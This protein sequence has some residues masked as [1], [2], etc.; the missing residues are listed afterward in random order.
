MTRRLLSIPVVVAIAVAAFTGTTA[1][2]P[3]GG[4][5]PCAD[6]TT[7]THNFPTPGSTYTLNM[8][9][10][11]AAPACIGRITYSVFVVNEASTPENP[12]P[13]HPA[14]L[15]GFSIDGN[16]TFTYTS[17]DD[18]I[19]VY[20]T[21][22]AKTGRVIDRAPDADATPNCLAL[23]AVGGGGGFN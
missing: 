12:L 19:C 23:P 7:E 17:A 16:P 20:A 13:D 3:G 6:I 10:F 5:P 8:E 22:S 14:T 4:G 21:T 2:A 18:T 1:A 11:L 15:T 9:V